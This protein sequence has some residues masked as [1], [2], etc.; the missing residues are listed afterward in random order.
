MFKISQNSANGKDERN[1][2][3]FLLNKKA[4]CSLQCSL[5]NQSL[6]SVVQPVAS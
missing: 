1:L 4:S 6:C 5:Q 2:I 3:G